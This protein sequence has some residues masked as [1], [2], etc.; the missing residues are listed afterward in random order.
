ML[1]RAKLL[2]VEDPHLVVVAHV[3]HAEFRLRLAEA[4]LA[5][6]TYNRFLPVYVARTT[7]K[8]LA[9]GMREVLAVEYGIKLHDAIAAARTLGTLTLDDHA[10]PVYVELHSELADD[11]TDIG[12][13]EEFTA[14]AAPYCLRIAGCTPPSP[15]GPTCP[16]R[17]C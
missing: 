13:V 1:T 12:R 17:T 11:A 2:K 16:P 8:P 15:D 6:G 9:T 7:K 4:N 5:G 3:T 14:R 10:R